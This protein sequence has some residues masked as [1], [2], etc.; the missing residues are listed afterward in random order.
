MP[1]KGFERTPGRRE[2][3]E[4]TSNGGEGG[5]AQGGPKQGPSLKDKVDKTMET[6]AAM[7]VSVEQIAQQNQRQQQSQSQ[8][9][10]GPQQ[11][12]GPQLDQNP[13][14]PQWGGQ[15]PQD[16]WGGNGQW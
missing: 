11:V 8:T 2:K 4:T 15:Y 7:A 13:W 14:G 9:P 5:N 1:P 16:Q 6:V 10:W 3:T 12:Q